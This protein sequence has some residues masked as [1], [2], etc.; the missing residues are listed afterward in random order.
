[1]IMGHVRDK[2]FCARAKI[3]YHQVTWV[4][5]LFARAKTHITTFGALGGLA[6]DSAYDIK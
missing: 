4:I 5:R 2:A 6:F 1:M 3:P